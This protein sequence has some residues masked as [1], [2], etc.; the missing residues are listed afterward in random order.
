MTSVNLQST[1]SYTLDPFLGSGAPSTESIELASIGQRLTELAWAGGL[2]DGEGCV[3]ISSGSVRLDVQ[4]TSRSTIQKLFDLFGGSCIV[5]SRRTKMGRPVFRW[6]LN[7]KKAKNILRKLSHYMVEKKRQ[8]EL[9]VSYSN[10]PP[11]SAM[12][13]SVER[14]IKQLKRVV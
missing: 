8:A 13:E 5:E 14:R 10:F 11:N 2:I 3:T 7:G 1:P 9:A 6:Y 12:R 4:S